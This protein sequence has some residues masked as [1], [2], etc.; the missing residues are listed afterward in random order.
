MILAFY[1]RQHLFYVVQTADAALPQREPCGV[2]VRL[3]TVL[4]I[5]TIESCPQHVI[6]EDLERHITFAQLSLEANG[7][8]V[9]ERQGGAHDDL[10][11]II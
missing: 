6:H 5:K 11:L 2:K 10:M 4:H 7:N 8:I 3:G 1:A 9:L